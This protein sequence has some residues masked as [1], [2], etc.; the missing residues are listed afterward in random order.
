MKCRR[1]RKLISKI[2][3]GNNRVVSTNLLARHLKCLTCSITLCIDMSMFICDI[4][5]WNFKYLHEYEVML[6]CDLHALNENEFWK[7]ISLFFFQIRE[8]L[9]EGKV[10]F[11]KISCESVS[12]VIW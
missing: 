5:P 7:K 2:V 4:E 10:W 12:W 11:Y 6:P 9:N 8:V 1:T 3:L